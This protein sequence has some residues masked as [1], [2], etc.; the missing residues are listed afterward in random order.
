MIN[1]SLVE[2]LFSETLED[3]PNLGCAM[4][5]AVCAEENISARLVHGQTYFLKQM[6]VSNINETWELFHSLTSKDIKDL[7]KHEKILDRLIS[8][9]KNAM[10][11]KLADLYQKLFVSKNPQYYLGQNLVFEFNNIKNCIMDIYIYTILRHREVFSLVNRYIDLIMIN[12]PQIVGFSMFQKKYDMFARF[13]RKTLKKRCPHIKIVLGGP[14]SP[15]LNNDNLKEIFL[16][17]YIDFLIVGHG[18]K[19]L[20]AL[21]HAIN[22]NVPLDHIENL[23]YL[24]DNNIIVNQ[25]K[26]ITDLETLPFPSFSQ[27]LLVRYF[28]LNTILP[29]LSAWGCS[30]RKC[31][32]CTHHSISLN[33]YQ[34]ATPARVA[35]MIVHL[36]EKYNCDYFCFHDEDLYPG[37]MRLLCES[38][39]EKKMDSVYFYGYGRLL[40]GF[41]DDSLLKLM[42]KTGFTGMA[43][44]LESGS[45]R[46]LG[47]MKKGINVTTAKKVLKKYHENGI[48]NLCFL[49]FGFPGETRVEAGE[50]INFL[51]QNADYISLVMAGPYDLNKDSHVWNNPESYGM[52]LN[53]DNYNY[54]VTDGMGAGEAKSF[55]I[56]FRFLVS[57]N[58]I[59]INN[60]LTGYLNPSSIYSRMQIFSLG[61]YGLL[62][63]SKAISMLKAGKVSDIFPIIM[64]Q[65]KRFNNGIVFYPVD[66]T[67][68][69]HLQSLSP[70]GPV[71]ITTDEQNFVNL[72]DGKKNIKEIIAILRKEDAVGN[73]QTS[74]EAVGFFTKI[75]S[76]NF[77]YAFQKRW[78]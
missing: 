35:D 18:D 25:R 45:Q 26:T 40:E 60:L 20:P 42:K 8:L 11:L 27:F 9:D 4:L 77:A 71:A 48:L 76:N 51:K 19:A 28:A 47:L 73:G 5:L 23:C 62:T 58:K 67:K 59:R 57:L 7:A 61:S 52:I 64:G 29:I 6:M 44:G 16:E 68:T 2:P 56:K 13:I 75:F 12:N 33:K 15:F 54:T 72:S 70:P 22:N 34:P 21:I 32:F 38:I 31:T 46:V 39:L 43:W 63:S 41:L 74:K 10:K 78:V 30:Y 3:R 17:E 1:F 55:F 65:V 14:F 50:T 69:M 53:K 36:R 49:F 37:R 66:I 24:K